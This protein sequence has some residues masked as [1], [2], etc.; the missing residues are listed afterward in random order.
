M[1][2]LSSHPGSW[3][4][5]GYKLPDYGLT[6][7]A[8]NVY[9]FLGGGQ[10]TAQ[11]GSDIIPNTSYA[12]TTNVPQPQVQG[13]STQFIGPQYY[14]P[15]NNTQP[16]NQGNPG[17]NGVGQQVS[18]VNQNSGDLQS[19][20]D[21]EF[22]QALNSIGQMEGAVQ[23][24]GGADIQSQQAAGLSATNR[25]GEAKTKNLQG[26][27]A[28]Q[29][30]A[31]NQANSGMRNARDL[32]RQIQQQNIAQLSG[33]GI[34]SSSVSEALAEKLGVE[35]ARRIGGITGSLDEV[36]QNIA[37]ERTNVETVFQNKIQEI[38]QQTDAAIAGI[39]AN[40]AD[41]LAKLGQLRG[42]AAV[43]KAKAK[44]DIA[45]NARNAIQQIMLESQ[46]RQQSIADAAAKRQQALQDAEQ[47]MFKPTDFSRINQYVS[48]VNSLPA[49]AGFKAVPTFENTSVMG[50]GYLKPGISYQKNPEDQIVN[51]FATP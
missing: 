36:R 33:L 47:F 37:K 5:G 50:Q 32:F 16:V 48:N 28:E 19:Q 17:N 13:A 11:G 42:Q 6:E 29:T 35:T 34:S 21:Y 2:V 20:A 41:Q 27:S 4:I 46:A 38:G 25:A 43:E 3:S 8:Q 12:Q 9:R 49:A 39:R 31:E 26:L 15:Q 1:T 23:Q 44:T 10:K 30:T 22:E 45:V 51:P 18:T 7:R 40:V 14:G 24:Q